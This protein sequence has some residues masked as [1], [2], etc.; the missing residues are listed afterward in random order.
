VKKIPLQPNLVAL[1]IQ[2]VRNANQATNRTR[3]FAGS[4]QV[5]FA[6]LIILELRKET[7]FRIL[8]RRRIRG[9]VGSIERSEG[10]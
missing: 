9:L 3:L 1:N 7:V 4:Q 10:E 5:L 2:M 6:S 8:T